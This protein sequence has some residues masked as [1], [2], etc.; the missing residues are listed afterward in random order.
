MKIISIQN[1]TT[2]PYLNLKSTTYENKTGKL[3]NYY[4]AERPGNKRA[5]MIVGITEQKALLIIKE[6]RVP[7]A[8]FEYGFPAGIIEAGEN[9]VEAADRELREETGYRIK[10]AI[11]PPSPFVYNTSGITDESICILFALIEPTGEGTKLEES[12]DIE[13]FLV[14]RNMITHLLSDPDK[15]FAAKAWIILQHFSLYGEI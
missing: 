7:L 14:S 13:A 8:G 2:T 4:W 3:Q 5:V 15:K 12:E 11:R 6:Y 9:V 10:A 1:L